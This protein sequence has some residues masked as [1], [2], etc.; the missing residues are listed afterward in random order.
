MIWW[1]RAPP[2]HADL[3]RRT[4]LRALLVTLRC[5][6]LMCTSCVPREADARKV[7]FGREMKN[8]SFVMSHDKIEPMIW[9]R[10]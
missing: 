8:R 7:D 1:V 2:K 3:V 6:G 9:E 10:F 5:D 4:P